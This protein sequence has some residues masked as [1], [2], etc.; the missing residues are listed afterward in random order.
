ML[1]IFKLYAIYVPH[2]TDY[3]Y[4]EFFKNFERVDSIHKLKWENPTF[5]NEDILLFGKNL[6]EIISDMR[7][8][9]SEN[10][11]SMK[12]ET[13]SLEIKTTAE[14]LEYFKQSEKDISA[15]SRAK[16]ITFTIIK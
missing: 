8:Y 9:K 2:I 5:L 15:C 4:Q 10:N 16:K 1:N 12:A 14:H 6:K 11:L 13:E 3:I 7:K